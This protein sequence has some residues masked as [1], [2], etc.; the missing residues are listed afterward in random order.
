MTLSI[1][2]LVVSGVAIWDVY[3]AQYFTID[4]RR[5]AVLV[6][7]GAAVAAVILWIVHAYAAV[8]VQGTIRA[9]MRGN[10]TGGWAWR[11]H[12]KW[13]RRRVDGAKRAPAE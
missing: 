6:H 2:V 9:M 4:Q 12:R 3:F 7:A 11:H 13:L 1:A 8:W 5:L 10:V